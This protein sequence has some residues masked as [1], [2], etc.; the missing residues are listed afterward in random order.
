MRAVLKGLSHIHA[1]NIVHR[2]LKP[3]NILIDKE[4]EVLKII[5]F[6]LAKKA[7]SAQEEGYVIGTLDFVAPE[8]YKMGASKESYKAPCDIWAAGLI[9]YNL[10]AGYNPM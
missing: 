1:R 9:C 7:D 10:L 2:D 3:R 6:G 4:R 8:I 5:D